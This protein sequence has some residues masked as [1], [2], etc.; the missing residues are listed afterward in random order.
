MAKAKIDTI[1]NVYQHSATTD[2]LSHRIRYNICALAV[3]V[4]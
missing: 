2:K 3:Y 1:P 4:P